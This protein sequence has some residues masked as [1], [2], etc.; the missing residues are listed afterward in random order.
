MLDYIVLQGIM[1]VNTFLRK[2]DISF[3]IHPSF[4]IYIVAMTF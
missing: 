2:K 1:K 4:I 3:K